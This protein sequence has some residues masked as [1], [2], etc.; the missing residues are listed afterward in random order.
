MEIGISRM[1]L[2][3]DEVIREQPLVGSMNCTFDKEGRAGDI[4]AWPSIDVLGL[5]QGCSVPRFSRVM[6]GMTDRIENAVMKLCILRHP[7]Y[8]VSKRVMGWNWP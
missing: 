5:M 8:I 7:Q 3:R 1:E 2:P 6:M 4:L